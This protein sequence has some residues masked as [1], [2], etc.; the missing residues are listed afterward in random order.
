MNNSKGPEIGGGEGFLHQS[1]PAEEVLAEKYGNNQSELGEPPTGDELVER[2][3]E[4]ESTLALAHTKSAQLEGKNDKLQ[5][6]NEALTAQIAEL[7]AQLEKQIEEEK[8]R[9]IFAELHLAVAE[10][11]EKLAQAKIKKLTEARAYAVKQRDEALRAA[12]QDGLTGLLNQ[13]A[14]E[15]VKSAE[16]D[17]NKPFQVMYIDLN[18]LK[19]IND[20]FDEGHQIGDEVLTGL[21]AIITR[22]IIETNPPLGAGDDEGYRAKAF[23]VGGDEFK[24]WI[25]KDEEIAEQIKQKISTRFDELLSADSKILG[26]PLAPAFADKEFS[27][28]LAIGYGA[29][30]YD[31]ETEMKKAKKAFYDE[32]GQERRQ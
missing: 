27:S 8:L 12:E 26:K 23:R 15:K 32:T 21:G 19:A 25:D 14:Y 2:L 16:Q 5:A 9:R 24:I 6:D 18:A 28:G 1:S 30:S 20:R 10:A 31:A 4:A 17:P 22:T 29:T 7:K 11:K 3:G 13:G